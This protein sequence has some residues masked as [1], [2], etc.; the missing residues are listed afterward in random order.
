MDREPE[1]TKLALIM[2]AG[3]LFAEHG[4]AGVGVRAIAEKAGANIAAINYHF[5][6]KEKLYEETLRYVALHG[7]DVR[8]SEYFKSHAGDKA[9]EEISKILYTFVKKT[10]VSHFSKENPRWFSKLIMRCL[11]ERTPSLISLEQEFFKPETEA[12]VSF[13]LKAN[14]AM[15]RDRAYSLVFFLHG[16]IFLYLLCREPVLMIM[17]KKGYDKELLDAATDQVA[18]AMIAVLG[19]PEPKE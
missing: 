19:L 17:G 7:K 1:G 9:P 14:P 11:L 5:G 4:L 18:L 12:F 13:L 10:F 16:Q 2:A 8:A 3:E 6:S 15:S